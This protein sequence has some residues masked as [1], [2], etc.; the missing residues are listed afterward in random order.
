MTSIARIRVRFGT[1]EPRQSGHPFTRTKPRLS[2]TRLAG[3]LRNGSVRFCTRELLPRS[4]SSQVQKRSRGVEKTPA[5]GLG[6]WWQVVLV[7]RAPPRDGS[8]VQSCG[9]RGRPRARSR[10][11]ASLDPLGVSLRPAPD[12]AFPARRGRFPGRLAPGGPARF[13]L[14]H[15][16]TGPPRKAAFAWRVGPV[17]ALRAAESLQIRLRVTDLNLF[18]FGVADS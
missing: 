12:T 2:S 6:G 17:C 8:H 4:G 18:A 10:P 9:E 7:N 1:R 13:S 16:A 3:D 5:S 14:T 11:D 15:G